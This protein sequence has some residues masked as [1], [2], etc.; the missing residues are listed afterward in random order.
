MSATKTENLALPWELRVDTESLSGKIMPGSGPTDGGMTIARVFGRIDD[1]SVLERAYFI[2]QAC[3][4]HHDLL[5]LVKYV[6]NYA[7]LADLGKDTVKRLD[8]AIA[9]AEGADHA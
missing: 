3:N 6:R 1:P 5:E 4:S 2:V 7:Q 8:A 9:K